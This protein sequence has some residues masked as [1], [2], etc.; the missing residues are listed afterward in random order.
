MAP[1]AV[2]G[3]MNA[4]DRSVLPRSGIPPGRQADGS[5][6]PPGGETLAALLARSQ[7]ALTSAFTAL[8]AATFDRRPAPGEWSAWD[9]AYHLAQIEV[10][11]V[12][13][14]CEAASPDRFA[15]M[16]RFL[17]LWDA[18]RREALALAGDLPAERLDVEGLLGGVPDWTPRQL[19]E[20]MAAHDREHA[21]QVWTAGADAGPAT[22]RDAAGKED[23]R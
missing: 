20:R 5:I 11:Y 13:K 10:W 9:I 12:A 22:G 7:H 23:R 1:R 8:T 19:V 3:A 15:A 16:E 6:G 21:A 18:M 2:A 17:H 4:E 14:L